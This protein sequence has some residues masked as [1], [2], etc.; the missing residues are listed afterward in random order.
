M[1]TYLSRYFAARTFEA[2]VFRVGDQ[3]P[4]EPEEVSG[5]SGGSTYLAVTY[6]KLRGVYY[7]VRDPKIARYLQ[8]LANEEEELRLL[9]EVILK[10]DVPSEV[11]E[12]SRNQAYA[13][14]LEEMILRDALRVSVAEAELK[15]DARKRFSDHKA[16]IE[17]LTYQGNVY[18]DSLA[19]EKAIKLERERLTELEEKRESEAKEAKLRQNDQYIHDK[20]VLSLNKWIDNTFDNLL[21]SL[22]K[23][24]RDLEIVTKVAK[25]LVTSKRVM[26]SY[27]LLSQ[28][29][30]K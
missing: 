5:G 27:K 16:R 4:P 6:V 15:E 1:N 24:R 30:N 9:K 12:E 8:G 10:A 7:L 22:E 14:A 3:G 28:W 2:D 17:E 29:S 23:A 26:D 25:P 18:L 20:M 19:E 11:T 13:L 21:F